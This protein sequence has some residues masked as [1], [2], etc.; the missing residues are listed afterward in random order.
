MAVKLNWDTIPDND[1]REP[2][3][4]GTYLVTLTGINEKSTSHGDPMWNLDFTVNEPKEY[5]GRHVFD[6]LVFSEAAYK[7][8]KLVCGRLGLPVKGEIELTPEML[9]GRQVI[10]DIIIGEYEGKKRNEVPFDGY[11]ALKDGVAASVKTGGPAA[12]SN[13]SASASDEKLPF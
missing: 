4:Q 11:I 9:R 12:K 1:T 8:V 10:L 6:N 13:V 3:P 7:R 2:L 5:V